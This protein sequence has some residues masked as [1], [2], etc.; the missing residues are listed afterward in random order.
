MSVPRLTVLMTVRNGEPY[1][2]EAVASILGQTYRDFRFL[3]LDNAS[4]DASREVIRCFGDSRIELVELPEDLGQTAA[5][6]KGLDMV[7]TPWVA[8]MDADDVSLPERLERQMEYLQGRSELVLM[9][10][11]VQVIDGRGQF[12]RERNVVVADVDIRWR[13]LLG[14]SGILHSAAMFSITA[15]REVGGYPIQYRYAQDYALWFRLLAVGQAANLPQRLVHIRAHEANVTDFERAEREIRCILQER[16]RQLCPDEADE[17]LAATAAALRGLSSD[18]AVAPSHAVFSCLTDLP[19]RFRRECGG[20][21]G[22]AQ[23]RRYGHRWLNMA[24]R[25][26]VWS[27]AGALN[28]IRLAVRVHPGLLMDGRF[29]YTLARMVI[30]PVTRPAPS[31]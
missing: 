5:L 7:E 18:A 20:D 8:R 26:S 17:T 15:I 31:A 19:A 22:G 2:R 4:T 25:A 28:W 27:T 6:N 29:W 16:L 23:L 30:A 24:R 12:V 9:G 13:Q 21:P 14:T 10:T 3:I 11:G 1:L